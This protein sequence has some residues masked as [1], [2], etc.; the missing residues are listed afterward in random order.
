MQ[1]L[2]GMSVSF[3]LFLL[4]LQPTMNTLEEGNTLLDQSLRGYTLPSS[5]ASCPLFTAQTASI[6]ELVN[7]VNLTDRTESVVP[8]SYQLRL[9]RSGSVSNCTCFTEAWY[10]VTEHRLFHRENNDRKEGLLLRICASLPFACLFHQSCIVFHVSPSTGCLKITTSPWNITIIRRFSCLNND[11]NAASLKT[12][13]SPC[14]NT[15][16]QLNTC[17]NTV[18]LNKSAYLWNHVAIA[19]RPSLFSLVIL[20]SVHSTP[21]ASWLSTLTVHGAAFGHHP[22]QDSHANVTSYGC[23]FLSA[24]KQVNDLVVL[25]DL[26]SLTSLQFLTHSFVCHKPSAV[27][28]SRRTVLSIDVT[29]DV[30]RTSKIN[31]TSDNPKDFSSAFTVRTPPSLVPSVNL[32]RFCPSADSH[33]G[34]KSLVF[35]VV[36]V[37]GCLCVYHMNTEFNRT[38]RDIHICVTIS[39]YSISKCHFV[40][41][42]TKENTIVYDRCSDLSVSSGKTLFGKRHLLQKLNNI[43][44]SA[45]LNVQL[46]T[47]RKFISSGGSDKFHYHCHTNCFCVKQLDMYMFPRT[48]NPPEFRVTPV[49]RFLPDATFNPDIDLAHLG[50]RLATLGALSG[51]FPVSRVK[52]ADAGFYFRGQ[53][54]EMTCYSC[55]VRHSGWT[56]GDNPIDVHRRLSPSCQHVREKD[57]EQSGGVGPR[58]SGDVAPTGTESRPLHSYAMVTGASPG[59]NTPVED[60]ET[61]PTQTASQPGERTSSL[62]ASGSAASPNAS[63]RTSAIISQSDSNSR[64]AESTARTAAAHSSSSSENRSSSR[65]LQNSTSNSTPQF[66]NNSSQVSNTT[67]SPA[68]NRT[69]S[70]S[71]ATLATSS[72]D[73]TR[74]PPTRPVSTNS[75]TRQ[76]SSDANN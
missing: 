30:S 68:A 17:S 66:S 54:D 4:L 65:P 35:T 52:L 1:T 8:L 43:K 22:K 75:S 63:H 58:G 7:L 60:S 48:F 56:R 36:A 3:I 5:K 53:G 32:V 44:L 25:T 72:N 61:T 6:G 2:M 12:S 38:D 20:K 21:N 10:I 16:D 51:S 47:D 23:N 45:H 71:S 74:D 28:K 39:A 70:N 41:E 34:V 26:L 50:Y 14:S 27:H 31:V 46:C 73:N 67:A 37:I 42:E 76:E 55:R 18:S 62:Q 13:A 40:T 9:T 11:V 29:D 15:T 19:P 59:M 24:I 49:T 69:S 57:G 33:C 64:P